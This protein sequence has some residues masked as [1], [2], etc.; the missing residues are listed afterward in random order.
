MLF[1]IA[2]VA[3][4]CGKDHGSAPE[5]FDVVAPPAPFDLAVEPGREQATI[6][7]SYQPASRALVDRFRIY[8]FFEVYDILELIASTADTYYVD[9][10]LVGNLR[11]CYVVSAVD[12]NGVEG[13]RTPAVCAIIET[14]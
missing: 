11:Y 14:R 4:S 2:A 1:V 6:T 3:V 10:R 7:W 5:P 12:T 9:E 8:Y 13:W